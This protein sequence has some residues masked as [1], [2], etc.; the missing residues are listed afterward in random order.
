MQEEDATRRL[1]K[2]DQVLPS[3]A[4]QQEVFER[5]HIPGLITKVIEGYN[6]TIFAYGQTSSGKTYTMEGYEY[7]SKGPEKAPK[8]IVRDSEHYGLAQRSLIEVFR[9]LERR[10]QER[11][12]RTSVTCSFVQIYNEKIYDLLNIGSETGLRVRW[13]KEEQFVVENLYSVESPSAAEAI[14]IYNRGIKNRIMATHNLNIASS[15]SHTVF[16]ITV[17]TTYMNQYVTPVWT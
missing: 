7:V 10:S 1:Y 6:A 13:N 8:L 4:G 5:L 2:F 17:K 16:T 12:V 11:L 9:Q 14:K 15:R 3:N